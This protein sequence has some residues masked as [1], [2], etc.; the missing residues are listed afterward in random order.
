MFVN[1]GPQSDGTTM[2]YLCYSFFFY[3]KIISGNLF[4]YVFN[5]CQL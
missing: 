3:V 5:F 1:I 4:F 2:S